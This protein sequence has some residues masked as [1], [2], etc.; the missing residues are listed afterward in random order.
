MEWLA[1]HLLEIILGLISAG[2]LAACKYFHSKVKQYKAY[3]KEK[4]Q[5]EIIALVQ[6]EV[7]PII[8]E[9]HELQQQLQGHE[10][11]EQKDVDAITYSYKFRL[12]QLCTKYLKQGYITPGQY[13]SLSEFYKVYTA[14]GGNGQAKTYYDKV[15][16]LEVRDH[17]IK[18]AET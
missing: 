6:E 8:K 10:K 18:N 2:S 15:Q 13:E 7:K 5:E 11:K 9:L 12:V 14:L 4:S 3:T 16:E 17:D 1:A